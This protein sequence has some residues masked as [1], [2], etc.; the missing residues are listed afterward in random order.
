[1]LIQP[2]AKGRRTKHTFYLKQIADKIES[3][4]QR[5]DVSGAWIQTV[6][7]ADALGIE[8]D[9]EYDYRRTSGTR[10]K[11]SKNR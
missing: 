3:L 7:M 10:R 6:I 4:A 8:L 2:K 11:T 1:M 9:N 5:H